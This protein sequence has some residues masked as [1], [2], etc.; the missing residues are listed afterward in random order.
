MI[1]KFDTENHELTE[2]LK[3]AHTQLQLQGRALK[4]ARKDKERYEK[5]IVDL[6]FQLGLPI[7]PNYKFE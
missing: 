4:K 2:K 3:D 7:D 5:V 6:R 1:E